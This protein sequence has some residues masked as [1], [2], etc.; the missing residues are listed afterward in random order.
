MSALKSWVIS[1]EHRQM[2]GSSLKL[3]LSSGGCKLKKENREPSRVPDTLTAL[4]LYL[5]TRSSN[6]FLVVSPF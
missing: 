1:H 3:E 5:D 4:A 6:S 2:R